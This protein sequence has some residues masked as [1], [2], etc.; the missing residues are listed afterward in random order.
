[1]HRSIR[2]SFQYFHNLVE[3]EDKKIMI[4]RVIGAVSEG[5]FQNCDTHISLTQSEQSGDDVRVW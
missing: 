5:M 3:S 2:Q 1:M 4:I